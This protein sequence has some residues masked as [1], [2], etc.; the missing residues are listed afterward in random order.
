M[1]LSFNS[2][3]YFHHC[4]IVSCLTMLCS[5]LAFQYST[6]EGNGALWTWIHSNNSYLQGRWKPC[7]QFGTV[8]KGWQHLLWCR[9]W[10]SVQSAVNEVPSWSSVSSTLVVTLVMVPVVFSRSQKW[11]CP[12]FWV[13]LHGNIF[14]GP[15]MPYLCNIAP[16]LIPRTRWSV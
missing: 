12:E 15:I 1:C 11:Q 5:A 16:A 13:K 10:P 7:I 3:T 2:F 8:G 4:S 14:G 9:V 6:S